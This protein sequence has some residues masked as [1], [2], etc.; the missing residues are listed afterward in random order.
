MRVTFD[1]YRDVVA[2]IA[3]E[4]TDENT[5]VPRSI[6]GTGFVIAPNLM[7]TCWHCVRNVL[8]S[9]YFYAAAYQEPGGRLKL[10]I[11]SNI[12]QDINGSDL[13]TAN[14]TWPFSIGL[15]LASKEA[16][17]SEDVWT[18]GHPLTDLE[19][20]NNSEVWL[21]L[22][23]QFLRTYVTRQIKHKYDQFPETLSYELGT[24]AHAG[25]SGA[26]LFRQSSSEVVGVIYGN[27][28]IGR[29][30]EF[31]HQGEETGQQIP[32]LQRIMSHGVALHTNTLRS[33]AGTA[34]ARMSLAEYVERC[35]PKS[36]LSDAPLEKSQQTVRALEARSVRSICPVCQKDGK[37]TANPY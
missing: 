29:I 9:G 36:P 7:V 24:A 30:V 23:P 17:T 33:L 13:A 16:T 35:F 11:L 22:A 4:R 28:D 21:N 15:R 12:S 10:A 8:P 34:T 2:I 32:E 37:R 3:A 1:L 18:A 6:H 19:R 5:G 26:P 20:R 31:A 25:L 27:N 14:L